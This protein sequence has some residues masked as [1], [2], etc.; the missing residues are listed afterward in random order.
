M[1]VAGGS[2]L[3]M[4]GDDMRA[5]ELTSITSD[6]VHSFTKDVVTVGVAGVVRKAAGRLVYE[7]GRRLWYFAL[8][9][10][11]EYTHVDTSFSSSALRAS[12]SLGVELS[13]SPKSHLQPPS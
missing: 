3:I 11:V 12:L 13:G 9:K 6:S 4:I 1:S 7:L 10:P 5:L 8:K 2:H